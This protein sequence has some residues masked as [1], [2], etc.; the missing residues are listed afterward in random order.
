[1][2]VVYMDCAGDREGKER[3]IKIKAE[4]ERK[5]ESIDE[6]EVLIIMGDFR[7]SWIP[8]GT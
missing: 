5:L 1:M 8:G 4:L 6:Q 7:F 2:I 3:N